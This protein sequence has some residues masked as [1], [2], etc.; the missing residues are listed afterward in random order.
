MKYELDQLLQQ[1][2]SPDQEPSL[3]L[4]Q[5]IIQKIKENEKMKRRKSRLS[6][7]IAAVAAT[8]MIASLGV[9]AGWKYL[10]PQKVAEEFADTEGA[11]FVNETQ[12]NADGT[13]RPDVADDAYGNEE[14]YISP[15]IK[16]LS[17]AECNVHTLGGGYSEDVL[18]GIQYRIME[19]DNIEM[20]AHRG[21]YLGVSDGTAPNANA[22]FMDSQTGEINLSFPIIGHFLVKILPM[23]R[24]LSFW[25]TEMSC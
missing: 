18:D 14:F 10:A 19:C 25:K 11:L 21:I 16:G 15:Y 1:A 20:F 5:K 12:E 6:I 17:M 23:L 13:P 24:P 22:Y 8:L 2:L 7:G 3:W 9:V 4:N